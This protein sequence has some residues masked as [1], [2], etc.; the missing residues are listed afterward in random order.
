MYIYKLSSPIL[1]SDCFYLPSDLLEQALA[2][3]PCMT[4]I[5]KTLCCDGGA[6]LNARCQDNWTDAQY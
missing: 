3:V 4:A 6:G 5:H 2:D 1:L